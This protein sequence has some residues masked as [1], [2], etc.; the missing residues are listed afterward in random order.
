MESIKKIRRVDPSVYTKEYYLTDCTGYKEFKE[1]YGTILEPRFEE[2][3]KYF[4]IK[5]GMHVL[6]I[7]CGRGELVL[8]AVKKGA[9]AV[10]IDYSKDAIRL[11]NRLYLN[12]PKS[13][14]EKMRFLEMDAKKLEFDNDMFD[15]IILTD[16]VEHLYPEELDMV[17]REIKRV[18]KNGGIVVMHTAPNKLFNNFTYKLYCY[19][20]SLLI[21]WLWNF[22][23]GRKYQNIAKPIE[24]RTDSHRIMHINEHTYF[25]LNNLFHK[26]KFFGNT[27]STNVTVKKPN[28][29]IQDVLF[30]FFVFLHPF[31]KYFP[32]NIT[33]GSDFVSVMVNRK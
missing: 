21:V 20:V 31:S 16:V 26:F 24:L 4:D 13:I 8:Y 23:L 27:V 2:L 10:G 6:D 7:G 30:N 15:L 11:A 14:Q 9:S 18:L 1:S 29:G 19:P 5:P 32:L 3:V 25:S 28:L 22:I 17:F 33:F 12:Q